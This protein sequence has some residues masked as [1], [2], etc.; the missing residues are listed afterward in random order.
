SPGYYSVFL[1]DPAI[2]VNLTV[3][4]HCGMHQYVVDK[5][6]SFHLMVDL[7]HSL[8]KKRPYWSCKILN[9]QIR[10]INNT[11]IEG[12][13]SITGWANERRVYFH[14]EFSQPFTAHEILAG[15]HLLKNEKTANDKYL[16][17]ALTFEGK[18]IRPLVVKVGLSSV[19]YA[20]ARANLKAEIP[21]FSFDKIKQKASSEWNRELSVFDISGT[22]KQKTI[23]YSTRF[24]AWFCSFK[25]KSNFPI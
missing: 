8:D 23:F 25:R 16:K 20:G 2:Q 22:E 12:Y 21:G 11:T 5:D 15:K 3:T 4:D 9:A 6:K 13:R 17:L 10:I 18:A 19:S 24:C 7:N 1:T 14:A